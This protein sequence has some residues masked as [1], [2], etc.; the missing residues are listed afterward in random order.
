ML[1]ELHPLVRDAFD[2]PARPVGLLELDMDALTEVARGSRFMEPISRYPAV[3]QDLAI[4]VD[5]DTPASEAER[6]IRAAGGRLLVGVT[7]FD[8]YRGEQIPE[9]KKS[10]AYSL[11][12]Q[13]LT[14]TLRDKQVAKLQGRI[15]KRL[16]KKIGAELRG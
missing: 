9:G 3:A 12:F 11:S 2:L 4:I 13:S 6:L 14:G 8:V 7:L 5:E 15:L 16:R 10:L 1:G